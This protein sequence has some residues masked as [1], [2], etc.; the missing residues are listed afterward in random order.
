MKK[1]AVLLSL[2]FASAAYGELYTWKDARGTAFYTNSLYE[3]PSRYRSKAKVLD[4]AT[5]KKS[6]LSTA[7]PAG[8]AVPAGAPLQQS[9][10]QAQ[11][12]QQP[13]QPVQQIPVPQLPTSAAPAN[14]AME[15]QMPARSARSARSA[16][17]AGQPRL[18]P[19]PTQMREQARRNRARAEEE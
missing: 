8:Q 9:A 13:V 5:G 11:S 18:R 15:N 6:P 12:V 19:T 10:I 16:A 7:Q 2:I 3:I 17:I 14:A 1:T 4:L